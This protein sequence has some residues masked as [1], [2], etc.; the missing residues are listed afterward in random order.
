MFKYDT[1][2][3]MK[4][5]R[6][7]KYSQGAAC[8]QRGLTVIAYIVR[9]I[10]STSVKATSVEM[11]QFTSQLTKRLNPDAQCHKVVHECVPIHNHTLGSEYWAVHRRSSNM[12]RSR[13]C[14][15]QS[16][17]GDNFELRS[18]SQ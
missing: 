4:V 13:H 3:L 5:S 7:T 15:G 17:A 11:R 1:D 6:D 16:V 18:H 8:D 9:K 12:D 10:Q 2:Q 14:G